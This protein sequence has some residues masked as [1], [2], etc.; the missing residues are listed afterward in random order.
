MAVTSY[1]VLF[2]GAG[3]N[4]LVAAA[5][6]ARAGLK[7]LVLER[8]TIVGGVAVTEEIC[9]GFR[10]STLAHAAQPAASVMNELRLAEHGL[11]LLD[12]DPWLFAPY[13]DGRSLV[14]SRDQAA[15]VSSIVQ[16][17]EADARA[18]PEFCATV[19]RVTRFIAESMASTPP[20]V[21][22]SARADLWALLKLGRRFRGLGKKDGYRL[23]RWL[24]MPAADFVSEWFQSEPLR[25]VMAAPGIFGTRFGPRSPGSTAVLLHQ[26]AVGD[27]IPRFVRG[28]MGAFTL[29][30]ASAARAAG[31]DIRTGAEVTRVD[32]RDGHA[33]GVSL[34]SGETLRANAVVSNA[35][36]RRTLLGMIDPV[37][38][39]PAF[40]GRV[41][42]YRCVGALAKINLAL[43]GLPTFTAVQRSNDTKPL[44]GRIHIGPNLDYLE[45]AFDA[46]KYGRCSS[47]P[48]LDITI[49]SL[50]DPQLAPPGKHVMSICAQFAPYHLRETDWN[51]AASA[52]ADTVI[53]T[54]AEYAPDIKRLIL[55]RQTITPRDLEVT[56]G[57]TGGHIFHGELALDQL[58][59][60]RPLIGW[61]RYRTPI[62][63]LYLCGS[64]THPGYGLSGLSGFNAAREILKDF[65][66]RSK[67]W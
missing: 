12:P 22:Q 44:S 18:Y 38:L 45:R 6:L 21:D 19:A 31:V 32:V 34:Q 63:G 46:S 52:F 25:S 3:H 43:S 10:C 39:E 47:R 56:Y 59:V 65:R 36:P 50:T 57:L 27:G 49:P 17:S 1:D 24:A 58:F 33:S 41:R 14:I 26:R 7:T 53:D 30:L 13:P 48:Y 40:V 66:R 35:D 54:L 16:F 23:L 20:D 8:R 29:A 28:G 61:A 9:P 64:G 51:A 4:G 62:R 2:V 11:E 60:T 55:H 5:L 15:T 67:S 37:Q 42:S